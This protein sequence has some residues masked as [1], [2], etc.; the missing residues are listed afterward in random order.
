MKDKPNEYKTK[1]V[2]V[3]EFYSTDKRARLTS[4]AKTKDK[5]S[6]LV[7]KVFPNGEETLDINLADLPK[8]VKRFIVPGISKDKPRKLRVRLNMEGDTVEMVSPVSGM[9]KA[10]L[11]GLGPKDQNGNYKLITKTYNKGAENENSHDEFIAIY[12]IIDGPFKGVEPPGYYL[13]YKYE[14]AEGDDEDFTRHN[15]TLTPQATQY[16]RLLDWEHI[17]GDIVEEE[18][19]WP[20]DGIIL[21]TLEERALAADREVNLIFENGNIASVQEVDSYDDPEPDAEEETEEEFDAK[22]SEEKED[23]PEVVEV[24]AKGKKAAPLPKKSAPVKAPAVKKPAAKKPV[25]DDDDDL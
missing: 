25:D 7:T 12:D 1:W 18:V 21:G 4:K 17:H 16:Q 22:F 13:H 10:K 2:G 3:V 19:Y 24:P 14:Q 5:K 6:N 20:D 23:E 11:I 9:H 8:I 15:C